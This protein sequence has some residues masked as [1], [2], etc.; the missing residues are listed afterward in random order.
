MSAP[1]HQLPRG[2]ARRL[3]ASCNT[4]NPGECMRGGCDATGALNRSMS[5]AQ[6]EEEKN[7]GEPEII[8][9][10]RKKW[11]LLL[12]FCLGFFIDVWS[13]SAFFIFTDPIS[14]DLGVPLAQ[15]SWVIVSAS[16]R[17]PLT[18]RRLTLSHLGHSCSS[19]AESRTCTLPS[20]SSAT[21]L[22]SSV[23]FSS[24]SPSSPIASPSSFSVRYPVSPE[25]A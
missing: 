21:A 12:V 9:S 23:F 14:E 11:S 2:L 19:G 1:I 8:V 4:I 7:D 13:S 18:S 5:I 3:S 10:Q 20:Q 17:L 22:S 16:C 24:S 25:L 15:Q 6:T